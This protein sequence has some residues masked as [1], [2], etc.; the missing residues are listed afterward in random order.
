MLRS[1]AVALLALLPGLSS[2]QEAPKP[3]SV[4]VAIRNARILPASGSEVPKGV[5]LIKDGKISAVGPAVEIPKDAVI[6]EA[7]GL[8]AMPGFVHP[9]TRIGGGGGTGGAAH[10]A[11]ADELNPAFESP[12]VLLRAGFTT[13]V[14]HP[15]G[16]PIAGQGSAFKPR[17]VTREQLLVQKS[18]TLRFDMEANT[19]TKDQLRQALENARKLKAGGKPDEKVE[20]IVKFLKGELPGLV[21]LSSP[22]EYLHWRQV[23]KPNDDPALRL[24]YVISSD[25]Y[26]AEA[27]ITGR[28]ER[29]LMRPLLASEPLTRNRVNTPAELVAAGCSVGFLPADSASELEGHLFRVAALVKAGFPREAALKA[30]T[31]VPAQA[32][33]LEGRVGSLEAGKDG[34]VLLFEGDPLE[35]APRLRK[36]L[37]DGRVEYEAR[38]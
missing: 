24:T 8:T 22:A 2:G 28:K 36:V 15:T 5:I 9:A 31:L 23:F 20:P 25:I 16:G 35:A 21:E 37:I 26:W 4:V 19:G 11:G 1:A 12:A 18:C 33:G 10:H 6:I 38:P 34:D 3:A 7:E 32:C 30:L 14:L 29:Y 27:Q 13:L 17:G